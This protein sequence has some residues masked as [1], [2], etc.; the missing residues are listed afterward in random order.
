MSDIL[1]DPGDRKR[2]YINPTI[3]RQILDTDFD[4]IADFML[5]LFKY[6]F[7]GIGAISKHSVSN[8]WSVTGRPLTYTMNELATT[9]FYPTSIFP[10][11][12]FDSAHDYFISLTNQHITHLQTQRN[13]S[14][15]QRDAWERYIARHLFSRLVS[16]YCIDNHGPFKLFC[17]DL[18]PPNM[19]VDPRTLRI[20]AVLDLEFTNS[21]PGQNRHGSYY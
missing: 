20:T 14:T 16:K 10:T 6:N 17:D 5:Q 7:C 12:P 1:K 19:L 4:Q 9:A 11:A 2:L 8:T 21:M 18:R 3:D 15:N 13:L